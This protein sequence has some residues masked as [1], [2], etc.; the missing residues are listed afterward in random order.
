MNKLNMI[1][2]NVFHTGILGTQDK[3][4]ACAYGLEGWACCLMGSMPP[5]KFGQGMASIGNL[6][7]IT[8]TMDNLMKY[9]DSLKTK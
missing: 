6:L 9:A 2:P 8:P 3:S 5:E 4:I 1:F 7:E